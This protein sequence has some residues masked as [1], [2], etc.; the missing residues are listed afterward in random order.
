MKIRPNCDNCG[1]QD[2]ETEKCGNLLMH[3]EFGINKQAKELLM[4]TRLTGFCER[5]QPK[6]HLA[7]KI[8]YNFSREEIATW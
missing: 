7:E 5:H 6:S 4:A 2:L 1:L 8:D 3:N